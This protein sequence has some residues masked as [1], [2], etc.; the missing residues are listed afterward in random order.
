MATHI[1]SRDDNSITFASQPN[2][3]QPETTLAVLPN[4]RFIVDGHD[5]SAKT[6]IADDPVVYITSNISHIVPNDN[7]NEQNCHASV[8]STKATLVAVVKLSQPIRYYDQHAW[9]SLT[10]I[11]PCQ[12]NPNDDC[13]TGNAAAIDL[14]QDFG[15]TDPNAQMKEIQGFITAINGPSV[16]IKSSSG[17]LFTITTPTDIVTDFNTNRSAGYNNKTVKIGSGLSVRYMENP[18]QHSKAIPGTSTLSVQLQLE[19]VSK[20][21]PINAY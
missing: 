12:G 14:Y 11:I 17:S 19:M 15:N 7:C 5:A 3:G 6:I 2:Y 9:S 8:Q 1:K 4:T 13:L 21:G 20:G 10:E 16:T 18:K